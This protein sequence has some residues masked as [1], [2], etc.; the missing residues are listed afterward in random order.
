[1]LDSVLERRKR[2]LKLFDRGEQRRLVLQ[3]LL[4]RR[5]I[6]NPPANGYP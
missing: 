1:V 2:T 4:L 5:D 3:S 6:P